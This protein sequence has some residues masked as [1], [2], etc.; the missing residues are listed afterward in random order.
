MTGV[1]TCALP[2]YNQ[3]AKA[4]KDSLFDK[5]LL[6][7]NSARRCDPSKGKEIDE[8]INAVFRGIQKQKQTAIDE[9]KRAEAQ[10]QRAEEQTK[11]AIEQKNKAEKQARNANNVATI[12]RTMGKDSTLA[13]R[14]MQYNYLHHDDEFTRDIYHQ[15]INNQQ[16]AF[17][18][19]ILRGHSEYVSA[20][21]FS[22][23]GKT[24]LTGSVD[25]TAKLWDMNTQKCLKTF[26]GHLAY[27]TAV[28]YSPDGKMIVTGNGGHVCQMSDKG[29]QTFLGV[30]VPQFS[31]FIRTARQ[32]RFAIGRKS[33]G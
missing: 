16:S 10:K 20:V 21:A 4:A 14:M 27:V 11:I 31:R 28:A 13:M 9:R 29:F 32:N 8:A 19:K 1:Q 22:P 23:D 33:N 30:H 7:F 3:G 12:M 2:I 26:V 17:L 15:T 25:K 24:V 5:A 18:L 6:C